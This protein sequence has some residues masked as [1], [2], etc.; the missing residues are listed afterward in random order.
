MGNNTRIFIYIAII[1]ILLALP[2]CKT[3]QTTSSSN[4]TT[5]DI[6]ELIIDIKANMNEQGDPYT[7]DSLHINN[8]ILSIFI[9]Y[10]GGCTQHDFNLYN[11][12]ITTRSLPPQTPVNLKH[13]SNQDM[14][15]QLI[16]EEL[17]FNIAKLKTNK[18]SSV[19]LIFGDGMKIKY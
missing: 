12:S 5:T 19:V 7:I 9:Q 6:K 8:N 13:N 1:A 17:K 11:N 18:D 16:S 2:N 14:C 15:R 3:K 10:S 4:E